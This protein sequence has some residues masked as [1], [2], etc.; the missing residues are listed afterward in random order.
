MVATD[1]REERVLFA[2]WRAGDQRAGFQLCK[3]H[4]AAVA[5]FF[6]RTIEEDSAALIQATFAG[7]FESLPRSRGE[8]SFRAC[9]FASAYRR[10]CERLLGRC[11]RS[12]LD[13]AAVSIAAL[14]PSDASGPGHEGRL[15]QAALRQLPLASQVMLEL[16]YEMGVA[17]GE[18]ADILEIPPSSARARLVGA[19]DQLEV[20]MRRLGR[21][22]PDLHDH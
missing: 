7:C 4:F 10:L 2:A 9:L 14:R 5:R 20:V 12:R 11:P 21:P 18:I 15:P 3:R 13:P 16:Y 17:L 8:A 19:R 22:G 1:I 6:R